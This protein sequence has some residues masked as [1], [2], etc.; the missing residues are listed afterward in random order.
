MNETIADVADELF[1][2]AAPHGLSLA[3]LLL[4]HGEVVFERYGQQPDT[5]FGPGGPVDAATR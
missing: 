1:A 2:D 4:Q 3:L 5:I